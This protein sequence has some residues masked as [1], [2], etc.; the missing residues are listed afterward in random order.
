MSHV[1]HAHNTRQKQTNKHNKRPKQRDNKPQTKTHKGSEAGSG[2][3]RT[4]KD[5]GE[6]S[7]RRPERAPGTAARSL[8]LIRKPKQSYGNDESRAAS[9]A[10]SVA[11]FFLPEPVAFRR[12]CG[13]ETYSRTSRE[14]NHHRQSVSAVKN[15]ALPTEPRGHLTQFQSIY[16][17]PST[18]DTHG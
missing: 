5:E 8:C 14:S 12:V 9:N 18:W 10:I 15:D 1:T 16:A 2:S 4:N 6:G 17:L 11:L 7:R 13:L 3:Q